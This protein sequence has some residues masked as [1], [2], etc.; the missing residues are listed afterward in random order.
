MKWLFVLAALVSVLVGCKSADTRTFYQKMEKVGLLGQHQLYR[1]ELPSEMNVRKLGGYFISSYKESEGVKS[2]RRLEFF[3][4]RVPREVISTTLPL[5]KI[6]FV[7][8]E[9][10]RIPTIRFVFSK[11]VTISAFDSND[12]RDG[13]RMDPNLWLT[14]RFYSKEFD[15]A[16]VWISQDDLNEVVLLPSSQSK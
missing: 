11:D 14:D 2:D 8:D 10:R 4:E 7:V 13:T 9:A 15:Y 16:V 1:N 5:S 6:R 3:W 12:L